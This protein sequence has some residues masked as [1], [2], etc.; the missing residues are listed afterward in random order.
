MSIGDGA[1]ILTMAAIY[2][3]VRGGLYPAKDADF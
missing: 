3:P 1:K 2:L